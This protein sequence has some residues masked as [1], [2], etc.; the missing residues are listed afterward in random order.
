[1]ITNVVP[2]EFSTDEATIKPFHSFV[3]IDRELRT[4][5]WTNKATA[6]RPTALFE[7][8]KLTVASLPGYQQS[9]SI[10]KNEVRTARGRILSNMVAKYF[11]MDKAEKVKN[12][13]PSAIRSTPQ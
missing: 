13:W 1:M 2:I 10:A 5:F 6:A 9:T 3:N 7:V 12:R 8:L 4:Q 11:P